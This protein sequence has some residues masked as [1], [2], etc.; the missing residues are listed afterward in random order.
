MRLHTCVIRARSAT[1]LIATSLNICIRISSGT[2]AIGHGGAGVPSISGGDGSIDKSEKLS[3]NC[4][5]VCGGPSGE[6]CAVLGT[7][8]D[9]LDGFGFVGFGGKADGGKCLFLYFRST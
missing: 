7:V 4:L 9:A 3:I 6:W 1:S 8:A 2:S 5:I